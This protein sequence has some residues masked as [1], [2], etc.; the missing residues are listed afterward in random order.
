MLRELKKYINKMKRI[1]K[2]TFKN[3]RTDIL[4]F[5][6]NIKQ[7]LISLMIKFINMQFKNK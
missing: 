5:S 7:K 1:I 6:I 2:K 3:Y 4:I